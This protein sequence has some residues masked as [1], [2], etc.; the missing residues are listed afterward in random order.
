MSLNMIRAATSEDRD[1]IRDFNIAMALET[2]D[3]VLDRE[4]LSRGV[5]A[6]IENPGR[7]FYLIAERDGAVVG[8]LMVTK[9]WSDWRNGDFWWI[10]SVYVKSA[11][12]R[13][14][15]YRDLYGRV[16]EMAKVADNVCGF[17]LYVEKE[18]QVAQ[19]TY[20]RLGM[21]ETH[22]KMYEELTDRD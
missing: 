20:E 13:Q 22:Y 16:K 3:K 9:E 12:R 7:G 10:E 15:I 5:S 4:T 2:E 11:F 19:E 21:R 1:A 18:N 17:R 8:S 6:L 14:G